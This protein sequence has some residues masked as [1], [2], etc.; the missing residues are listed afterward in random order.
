[1]LDESKSERRELNPGLTHPKGKYYRY[2]TLRGPAKSGE[3]LLYNNPLL[4]R[5]ES[6]QIL[7]LDKVYLAR[8]L[9]KVLMHLVQ[10]LIFSPPGKVT[11]CKLGCCR[12]LAVGLNLVARRRTRIQAIIPFFSQS[13]QIFDIDL[14]F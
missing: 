11:D 6:E 14:F 8:V 10:A 13:W 4:R 2:T 7:P 5:I 12:R 1:M 3:K 9:F